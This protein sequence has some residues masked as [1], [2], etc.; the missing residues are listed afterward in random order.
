MS[1]ST[2][3]VISWPAFDALLMLRRK[4]VMRDVKER[5]RDIEGCIKQ[6]TSFVK[7]NFQRHVYPQRDHAG[8]T[9]LIYLTLKA[10]A[11]KSSVQIS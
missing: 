8:E 5:G 9:T 4:Q 6:W 3:Y 10:K 2:K 7:P 1:C 11:D